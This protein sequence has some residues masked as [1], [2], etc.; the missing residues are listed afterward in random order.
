MERNNRTCVKVMKKSLLIYTMLSLLPLGAMAEIKTDKIYADHMVLQQGKSVP[1]TGTCDGKGKLTVS[2]NGQEVQAT[3]KRGKWRAVLA[4]MQ[5]NAKG[6]ELTITQGSDS[7][8]LQDV[9]VGEVWVASGQSNMLWRLN[10]TG[11]R[12]ALQEAETPLFRFYH[13]Q[14]QVHTNAAE[15]GTREKNI[16]KNNEMYQGS[17]CLNTTK[18]RPTMSAVGYYFGRELQKQLEV[19]VAVVHAALGGS[20]MMAWMPPA[21]LKKSYRE[22][23]TSAWLE[24]KYMSA[25]VRGRARKNIGK[26]LNAPHPYQP[27]YLFRTGI[28]PWVDFPVAG[29]I[30]YQ[31]ESDAEIQDMEQ[32]YALLC[33]LISGWRKEFGNKELPFVQVELPRINDKSALRAYWP[34]FRAV[35]RRAANSM[36]NVYSLTTLDLGSTNSDVHPPRKVEV[37][38]RLAALAAAKVYGKDV[39]ASGPVVAKVAPRGNSLV[40]HFNCAKGLTTTDGAA[41][42]GFEVSSNGKTYY[43]ATAR[44]EGESVVLESAEVK[45]PKYARY[46]WCTFMNPNLVNEA[47]LPA[48]P[49]TAPSKRKK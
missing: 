30:W 19:P 48:V 35:Q 17:W 43:P 24:S 21:V 9:L 46:A 23:T 28:G 14:P 42:V 32:N 27:G 22:C 5:A 31:G 4:P 44:I 15:Y 7:L 2:F 3:V 33:D 49:Y 34:E 47:G 25:W 41:P 39:A 40:L 16:L 45:A 37:G 20:E 13:S 26:D 11:D 29:V 36:K 10:Q 38:S 12:A 1:I 6:Q 8:V 18:A